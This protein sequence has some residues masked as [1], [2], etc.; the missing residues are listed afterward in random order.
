[1]STKPDQEVLAKFCRDNGIDIVLIYCEE[2]SDR[3]NGFR[4]RVFAPK[5]GYLEDPATGSGNSA[6]G[7]HLLKEGRWGGDLLLIEQGPDRE[8]P[9]IIKLRTS[10][11]G[12]ERRVMFG[13]SAVIR[14]EKRMSL[15]K[16]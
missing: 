12:Q 15:G 2:T 3:A 6:F 7:Y 13:G 1:L 16:K 14:Y 11:S 9:N 8:S 5:Y 4:T 10:L